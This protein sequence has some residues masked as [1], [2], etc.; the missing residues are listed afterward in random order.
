MC[1]CGGNWFNQ[2]IDIL[3]HI[4]QFFSNHLI[5]KIPDAFS[6][7]EEKIHTSDCQPLTAHL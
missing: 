2:F 3:K 1:V 7:K 5:M 4:V 6:A